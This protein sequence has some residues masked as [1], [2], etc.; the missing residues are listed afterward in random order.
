MITQT[1]RIDAGNIDP[2]KIKR[3]AKVIKTGG[4]V[5]FPTETV[6]GLAADYANAAAVKRIYAVK[7]RPSTKA[8]P[9]Q[10]SDI[11]F[12]ERLG[13][14][15]PVAAYPLISA[16]WPGPLTL[17]FK[18]GGQATLGVRIPDNPVA[19]ALIKASACA[20][21]APSANISGEPPATSAQEVL[22]I[23]DGRIEMIIDAGETKLQVPST[24][25]DVSVSPFKIIREGAISRKDLERVQK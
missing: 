23:F 20:I 18:T 4:I 14:N 9:V 3:A 5:A 24:V 1:V 22:R 12:L 7:K 16:F 8:L 19:R 25:I 10:I 17:I 6:Y 13:C 2:K 11:A 21:V 15:V